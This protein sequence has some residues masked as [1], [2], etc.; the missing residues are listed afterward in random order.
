MFWN[1]TGVATD[2]MNLDNLENLGNLKVM[3]ENSCKMCFYLWCVIICN[4]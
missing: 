1:F 3:A 4:G 2:L